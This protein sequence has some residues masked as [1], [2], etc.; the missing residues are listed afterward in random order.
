[1]YLKG[2]CRVQ[3]TNIP[4]NHELPQTFR[5]LIVVGKKERNEKGDT[6]GRKSM[7][8]LYFMPSPPERV[9]TKKGEKVQQDGR[10]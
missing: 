8:N 9:K 10:R 7:N 3:I 6:S 4:R 1:M 5:M 2:Y